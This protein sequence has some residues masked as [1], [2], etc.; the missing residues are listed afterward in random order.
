[1][2]GTPEQYQESEE[3]TA[4]HEEYESAAYQSGNIQEP[5]KD[6]LEPENQPEVIPVQDEQEQSQYSQTAE[7]DQGY[8]NADFKEQ[9]YVHR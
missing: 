8:T 7:G 1:V 4:N 9:Q 6:E 2:E 3:N 5:H